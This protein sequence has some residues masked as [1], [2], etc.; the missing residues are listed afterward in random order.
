MSM[1]LTLAELKS[2]IREAIGDRSWPGDKAHLICWALSRGGQPMSRREVMKVVWEL[3]GL[4]PEEFKPDTNHDYWSPPESW[5]HDGWE[6]DPEAGEGRYRQINRRRVPHTGVHAKYSVLRRGFVK[7]AGKRGNTLL[8]ELTPDGQQLAR[9]C[10][11]W[12]KSRPDLFP[13]QPG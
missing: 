6:P 10:D 7:V 9:E 12:M 1:E 3:E 5:G 11:E 13:P 2:V 4:S 8:F